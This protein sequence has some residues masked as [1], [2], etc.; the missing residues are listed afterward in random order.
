MPSKTKEIFVCRECGYESPRWEGQ[1]RSCSAWNSYERSTHVSFGKASKSLNRAKKSPKKLSDIN[2]SEQSRIPTGIAE[3]DRTLGGGL[4]SGQVILLGGTPGVGKSTLLL[5]LAG[6]FTKKVLYV[7]GEESESQ[8]ALRSKRLGISS[9]DV[10]IMSTNSIDDALVDI[11]QKLLIVDSIQVMESEEIPSR[12]GSVTQVRE[13]AAKIVNTTKSNGFST[14]IIGH[15]TKEGSIA[16]PKILEHMVDTVLY[17]EGDKSHLF[18]MLRVHKNR[19]GDDS[20]VGIFQMQ[21]DGLCGVENPG[22]LLLGEEGVPKSGSA[23]AIVLE[24]SRPLCIEIQALTTKTSFG[25]P[26]RAV[27]GYSLNR[28]QLLCAVIQK[29][30]NINLIDQDVYV[31]VASGLNVKEPAVDLAV[32]AAII[33]SYKGRPIPKESAYF[34]EVGLTGE[35]RKVVASDR[36]I[37]EA[38]ALGFTN[39]RYPDNVKN[40]ASVL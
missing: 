23:T 32:C 4:V 27:S 24:G 12:A 5:Q 35:V 6:L 38:K 26:K 10:N 17:L 34:G 2:T 31:N 7:S 14:I 1:C 21:P 29:C 9:D 18:R 3:L 8:I 33:S 37:K 19:F 15:I 22:K 39:I 28:L 20:E 30:L 16:G 11:G 40:I 13:C 36:R 25:Y